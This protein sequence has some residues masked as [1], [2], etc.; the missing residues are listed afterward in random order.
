MLF[1][2]YT[3]INQEKKIE[4][5]FSKTAIKFTASRVVELLSDDEFGLS[6]IRKG[7]P[8]NLPW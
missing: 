5:L 2:N 4:H 1:M 3:V 6:C 7:R 8:L